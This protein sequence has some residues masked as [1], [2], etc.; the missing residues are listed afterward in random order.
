MG[1]GL[2]RILWSLEKERGNKVKECCGNCKYNSV[3]RN[4]TGMNKLVFYCGNEDSTEYGS[5]TFYDDSCEDFEE[6]E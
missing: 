2:A 6:K 3:D 1:K 4:R 5:P